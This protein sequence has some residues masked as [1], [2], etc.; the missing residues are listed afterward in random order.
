[1][2]L[3]YYFKFVDN[4]AVYNGCIVKKNSPSP[5]LIAIKKCVKVL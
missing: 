3:E 1:M 5:K 2:I 4:L